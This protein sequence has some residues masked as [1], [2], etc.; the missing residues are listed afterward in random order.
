MSTGMRLRICLLATVLALAACGGSEEGTSSTAGPD[1]PEVSTTDA[2]GSGDGSQEPTDTTA[3]ASSSDA[4][5]AR[6]V[7]VDEATIIV[8]GETFLFSEGSRCDPDR[9]GIVFEADLRR[10]DENGDPIGI[11]GMEDATN[12]AYF[13]FD[14]EG[15][16][17]AED[18]T[19][20]YFYGDIDSSGDTEWWASHLSH[21]GSGVDSVTIEGNYAHGTAT[22]VSSEGDGPVSGTFEVICANE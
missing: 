21:E 16:G 20:I 18:L 6:E 12:S 22:F 14:H 7:D 13:V 15:S 1:A 19:N 9:G 11:P 2:S 17:G 3:P 10:V 5:G 8:G 4:G